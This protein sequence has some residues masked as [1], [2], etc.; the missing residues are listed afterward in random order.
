MLEFKNI[1]INNFLLSA[2]KNDPKCSA[3]KTRLPDSVQAKHALLG[4]L[5]VKTLL[6]CASNPPIDACRRIDVTAG[7]PT[8]KTA[9]KPGH[10]DYLFQ[11]GARSANR[12]GVV[13]D[14]HGVQSGVV[15]GF[16]HERYAHAGNV[17]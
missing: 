5:I 10:H 14:L 4:Q 11:P 16:V 2:T 1:L 9:W 6:V 15:G 12:R 13:A 17:H 3:R 7:F 8:A